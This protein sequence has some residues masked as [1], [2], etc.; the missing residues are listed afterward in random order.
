MHTTAN[1]IQTYNLSPQDRTYLV[2]PLFH[3]HVRD[4]VLFDGRCSNCSQGMLCAFLA[5]LAAGSSITLPRGG[6]FSATVFWHDFVSTRCNWYTAVPTIHSILLNAAK[7]GKGD[8]AGP[9][10]SGFKGASE[11][12]S[13]PSLFGA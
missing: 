9:F 12:I 2:M 10:S 5:P 13:L 8:E 1:I 6:K 7:T 3:V 11:L 4:L